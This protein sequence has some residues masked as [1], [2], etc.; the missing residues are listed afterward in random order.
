MRVFLSTVVLSASVLFVSSTRSAVAQ[1]TATGVQ[2]ALNYD[3]FI[4]PVTGG[5]YTDPVFGSTIK[6][7]SNASAT[8]NADRGGYLTWIE[9][10]YSTASSFNSDNSK[11]ILVH[12]SYFGLYDGSGFY[13]HDLPLEINSSS[14][15]RW[16]RKDNAALYYHSGNQLK[17]YNIASGGINV[18]HIFSEYSSISGEGKMDMSEDGD[19]LVLIG[20]NHEAFVYVISQDKKGPVLETQQQARNMLL[21]PNNNVAISWIAHGTGRMQGL[22][23]YDSNMNFLRQISHAEG[24]SHMSRDTNGDEVLIWTNSADPQPIPNCQN[25]IVKVRL[26]D[27]QQTCLLQLDWSLAVHISASDGNGTA[28]VDTEAP[29]NPESGSSHWVA[30]TDELL[31]VR[32]D[33]SG[34]TRLAH[35]RSR[36]VNSYNWQP[37]LSVSRDGTRLLYASNYDLSAISGYTAEY[38]DTYMIVLNGST[39]A[40]PTSSTPPPPSPPTTGP[41]VVR[42]EQSDPAVQYSGSWYPN[43]GGFNSGGSAVLAMDANAQAKFTF[44]GTGVKWIGFRDA[45]SGIAQVYVDGVLTVTVDTYSAN[46]QAQ[47][48]QYSVTNLSNGSHTLTIVLTGTN[49]SASAGSWVWVDAFDVTS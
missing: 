39:A 13:I 48:V 21:S 18:I 24:H 33:G 20:D 28:F 34:V 32:L 22:E 30:Y 31:Q 47:A 36:P 37:K 27:A 41:K 38:S 40:P 42:Y 4:P 17:S 43:H 19:H 29:S 6:R 45:W 12:E 35:H 11:F 5:T 15:P 44:T 14:E 26:A 9:N 2:P 23:L 25:G 3:S 8:P 46:D 49:G 10:E 1:V 16:S 7:V